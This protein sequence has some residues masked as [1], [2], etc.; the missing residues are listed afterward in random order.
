MPSQVLK[1][2]EQNLGNAHDAFRQKMGRSEIE[3]LSGSVLKKGDLQMVGLVSLY[4]CYDCWSSVIQWPSLAPGGP[5]S[6]GAESLLVKKQPGVTMGW[7]HQTGSARM[8]WCDGSVESDQNSCL[9][10]LSIMVSY[11][12]AAISKDFG[13]A[14]EPFVRWIVFKL[15]RQDWRRLAQR[16]AIRII[17]QWCTRG[18]LSTII[19]RVAN[20][21]S[22]CAIYYIDVFFLPV[23][24]WWTSHMFLRNVGK[25]MA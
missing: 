16:T 18:E 1:I 6:F 21:Q 8:L 14:L 7:W 23:C 11:V 4:D 20:T 3:W 9:K 24:P 19:S 22:R 25:S 17:R 15:F 10:S 12:R 13:F 5:V 2:V